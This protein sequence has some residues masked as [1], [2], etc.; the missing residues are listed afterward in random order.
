MAWL[1]DTFWYTVEE[2]A[3]I[4]KLDYKTALEVVKK[5]I[6]YKEVNGRYKISEGDFLRYLCNEDVFDSA[7]FCNI[8]L[9]NYLW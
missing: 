5:H 8:P 9:L 1:D 6:P 2:L 7:I 4:M 3:H